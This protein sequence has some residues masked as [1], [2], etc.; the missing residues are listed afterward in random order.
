[1]VVK[2]THNGEVR[3]IADVVAQKLIAAGRSRPR[4][5]LE[6]RSR[7]RNKA[8]NWEPEKLMGRKLTDERQLTWREAL[9]FLDDYQFEEFMRAEI[10]AWEGGIDRECFYTI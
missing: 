5:A 1:M 9:H 2:M 10:K 3:D 7:R 8:G 4:I 6:S